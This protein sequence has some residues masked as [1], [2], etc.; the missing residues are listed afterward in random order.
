MKR[1]LLATLLTAA[2]SSGYYY[3]DYSFGTATD[4]RSVQAP[5]AELVAAEV[6]K[7]SVPIEV[8]A[9]GNVQSIATVQ[10]ISVAERKP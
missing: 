2:V 1:L 9:I 8:T 7:M 3:W 10:P 5:A 4:T 6:A